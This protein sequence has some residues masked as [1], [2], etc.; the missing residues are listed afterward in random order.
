[1]FL[2]ELQNK[3]IINTNTGKKLGRIIDV[4][5]DDKGSIIYLII[6]QKKLSLTSSDLKVEY[7]KI[8]KIGEDVILVNI[9][10]N[11]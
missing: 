3:D 6:E 11:V 10:Y 8:S 5:I 1:M 7:S 9:W 2:S 4:K